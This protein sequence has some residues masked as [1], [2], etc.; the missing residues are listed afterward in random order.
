MYT[1]PP[2]AQVADIEARRPIKGWRGVYTAKRDDPEEH[3]GASVQ[4]VEDMSEVASATGD[5]DT[6]PR[7]LDD[8]DFHSAVREE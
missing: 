8:D 5:L 3:V 4:F 7:M 2:P 6:G 1:Y